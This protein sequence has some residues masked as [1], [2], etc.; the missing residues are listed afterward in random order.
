MFRN[1]DTYGFRLK[2]RNDDVRAVSSSAILPITDL[3]VKLIP[4]KHIFDS[5][6]ICLW[7][8]LQEL[9]DLTAATT[10]VMD[11]LSDLLRKPSIAAVL[12]K[13]A[14]KFLEN[15]V[16]QLYPFFRSFFYCL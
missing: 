1:L 16:P 14:S 13:E 11:L 8:S 12:Q 9:D 10:S 5:V 7:D 3:L 15:L 6:V 4:E 2:D